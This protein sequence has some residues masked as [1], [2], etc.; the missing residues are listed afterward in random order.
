MKE[1]KINGRYAVPVRLIPF[2]TEWNEF[3]PDSMARKLSHRGEFDDAMTAYHLISDKEFREMNPKEWDGVVDNIEVLTI[4]LKQDE[5][6]KNVKNLNAEAWRIQA[7]EKLPSSVFVWLDDL[8]AVFGNVMGRKRFAKYPG[9]LGDDVPIERPGDRELN[10][11][12]HISPNQVKIVFDGF[13]QDEYVVL[14]TVAG[15]AQ[16]KQPEPKDVHSAEEILEARRQRLEGAITPKG[17]GGAWS[18][19]R[20]VWATHEMPDWE[21]WRDMPAVELW[22]ACALSCNLDP[23]SLAFSN[24]GKGGKSH[25]Q[26]SSFPNEETWE[27][28]IKRQ[29][30]LKAKMQQ[31]NGRFSHSIRLADFVTWALSLS[32]PWDMPELVALAQKP[33][34]WAGALSSEAIPDTGQKTGEGEQKQLQPPG[35]LS[36]VEL[37]SWQSKRLGKLSRQ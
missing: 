25:I 7:I 29:R 11:S 33:K 2:M 15:E 14:A 24:D 8:R 34:V 21:F 9:E 30:L 17:S 19:R 10:L 16:P 32:T 3:A 13:P 5:E 37:E 28:F 27:L 35:I 20:E 22:Q 4:K 26:M 31:P 36:P 12:P 23:D 18:G 1:I 6:L